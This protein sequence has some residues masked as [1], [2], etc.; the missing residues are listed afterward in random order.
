RVVRMHLARSLIFAG[1]FSEGL[2][3]TEEAMERLAPDPTL[4]IDLLGYSPYTMLAVI[5]ADFLIFIGHTSEAV[6]WYE[7]AIQRARDDNDLMMLGVAYADYSGFYDAYLGDAQVALTHARQGV[8]F[9]E[10]AGGPFTRIFAY[11]HLGQA[12]L[13][14]SSYAEAMT[15]LEEAREIIRVSHTGFEMEPAAA[16]FLAE[17]YAYSGD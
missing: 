11:V 13:E 16:V 5:R 10:K 2:T 3:C 8:E 4:G 1:R 17:T 12:Y 9:G 6:Q 7:K 15:S 14:T